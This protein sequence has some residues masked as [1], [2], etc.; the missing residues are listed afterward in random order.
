MLTSAT[1]LDDV[2][3]H[4][5]GVTV[6]EYNLE[7]DDMEERRV[8]VTTVVTHPAY[9]LGRGIL[10]AYNVAI[11][12][13]FPRLDFSSRNSVVAPICWG[14]LPDLDTN[15]SNIYTSWGSTQFGPAVIPYS[16][17]LP[18]V[19]KYICQVCLG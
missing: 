4:S 17:S 6:S 19:D 11:L 13:I 16:A 15:V 14:K 10:P 9:T 18:I 7:E 8:L 3:S 1:C 5:L 2:S 12:K